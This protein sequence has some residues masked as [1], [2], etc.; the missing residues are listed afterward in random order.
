MKYIKI[1]GK[2]SVTVSGKQGNMNKF[3]FNSKKKKK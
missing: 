2:K 1:G 3:I